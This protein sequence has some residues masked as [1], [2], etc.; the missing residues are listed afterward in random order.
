[1][2]E[3]Q[4]AKVNHSASPATEV[5][6]PKGLEGVPCPPAVKKHRGVFWSDE[7]HVLYILF[8]EKNK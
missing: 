2:A 7:E 1:M 8:L 3:T 4:Q 5:S 6:P